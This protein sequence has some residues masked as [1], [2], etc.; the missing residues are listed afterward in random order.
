MLKTLDKIKELTDILTVD[1]NKAYKGNV[2]AGIRARKTAQEL[3]SF[4][5][6]LRVEILENKKINDRDE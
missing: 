6:Q 5:Q 4:L 2:S 1:T 3:K